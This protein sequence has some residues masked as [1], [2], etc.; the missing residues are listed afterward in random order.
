MNQQL[1]ASVTSEA[2]PQSGQ[3][4]RSSGNFSTE[5]APPNTRNLLWKVV[6]LDEGIPPSGIKF[7]VMEDK[8]GK[9]PTIWTDVSNDLFTNY[10]SSRSLYI[11]NPSGS[12]PSGFKVL[13]YAVT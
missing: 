13:V 3:K 5:N 2:G 11:A 8:R 1:L 4:N 6:P 7:E 10:Q 12:G 9:D